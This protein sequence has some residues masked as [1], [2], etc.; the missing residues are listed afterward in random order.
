MGPAALEVAFPAETVAE[1][2]VACR[3]LRLEVHRIGPVVDPGK[4]RQIARLP[5][6]VVAWDRAWGIVARF[7]VY[8]VYLSVWLDP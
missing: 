3:G 1:M 5:S 2:A 8:L 7:Q 6:L 4:A